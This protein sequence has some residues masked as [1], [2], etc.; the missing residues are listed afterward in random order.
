MKKETPKPLLVRFYKDQRKF[1]KQEAKRGKCSEAE[2][3]RICVD[4]LLSIK[5]TCNEI[6]DK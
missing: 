2:I 1:I 6:K 5:E 4:R 3:V